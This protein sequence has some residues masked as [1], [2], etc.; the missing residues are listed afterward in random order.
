MSSCAS[1]EP[2]I[3]FLLP[4]FEGES[5][6]WLLIRPDG[7]FIIG[8]SERPFWSESGKLNGKWGRYSG[9]QPVDPVCVCRPLIGPLVTS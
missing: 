5:G 3:I 9:R 7:V 4:A 2:K 1:G 6:N 8:Q